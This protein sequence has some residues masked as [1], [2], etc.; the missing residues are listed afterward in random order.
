MSAL[1][2]QRTSEWKP[3][4]SAFES[5]AGRLTG[6]DAMVEA[7]VMNK[8]FYFLTSPKPL[9]VMGTGWIGQLATKDRSEAVPRRPADRARLSLIGKMSLAHIE[10]SFDSATR[11]VLQFALTK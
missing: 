6:P 11:L 3:A 2:H 8:T 9:R 7:Q 5:G 10:L 1:G 4:M